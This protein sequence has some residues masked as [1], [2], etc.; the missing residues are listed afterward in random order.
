MGIAA[1]LVWRRHG[2]AQAR[3]ALALFLVQLIFNAAWSWLFFGLRRPDLAFAEI[4]LLWMLILA[5]LVAFWRHHRLAGALLVAYLAW[6]TF[7]GALNFSIWRLNP[8]A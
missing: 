8:L 7:A 6:V 3:V 1:W 4:V 5:T 2:F